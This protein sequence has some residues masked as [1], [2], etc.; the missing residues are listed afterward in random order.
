MLPENYWDVVL[1]EVLHKEEPDYSFMFTAN[2]GFAQ[3][4]EPAAE[5]VACAPCKANEFRKYYL[6][7]SY[8]S[9]YFTQ[10]EYEC[11]VG[12]LQG[13]SVKEIAAALEL[14]P[15]TVEYYI[16]NMKGKL[17][18]ATRAQLIKEVMM[19][20]IYTHMLKDENTEY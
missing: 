2:G 14:S 19:T 3:T 7:S 9:V 8:P 5:Y 4:Q 15:R 11:M 12:L 6:G 20:D 1:Q 16:K 17:G 13:A 18:C 10:R